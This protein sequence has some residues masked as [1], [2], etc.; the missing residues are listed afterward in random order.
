M[1]KRVFTHLTRLIDFL[2]YFSVIY[3]PFVV[4]TPCIET[5]C[6]GAAG[7]IKL[8]SRLWDNK[9]RAII[10]KKTNNIIKK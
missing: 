5:F 9:K 10:E 4:I 1:K 6:R 3:K 7:D 8:M 2:G